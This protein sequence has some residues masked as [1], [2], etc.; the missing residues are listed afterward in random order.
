MT[1]FIV[2]LAVASLINLCPLSERSSISTGIVRE[3]D[4]ADETLSLEGEE[5]FN[6]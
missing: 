3:R 2:L 4:R 6:D 5:V 1:G